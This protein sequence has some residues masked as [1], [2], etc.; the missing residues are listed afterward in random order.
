MRD[1]P[2]PT[3]NRLRPATLAL[4]AGLLAAA[5]G[6]TLKTNVAATGGSAGNVSH[7]WLTVNEVWLA[8]D[9][10]TPP[11]ATSGWNK[12][13]LASPV[14]FDLAT[15]SNSTLEQLASEVTTASGTYRQ[16]HLVLADSGDALTASAQ[17]VGIAS[18]AQITITNASGTLATAPLEAAVPGF[19]LTIAC[20]L[21]LTGSFALG[22]SSSTTTSTTTTGTSTGATDTGGTSGAT[23]G[24]STPSTATLALT[25]D[26]ARDVLPYTYGTSTG[27][28]LSPITAVADESRAGG[29]SGT[30]DPSALA[31]GSG[32][33]SVS[34]EIPD[35]TSTHHVIVQRRVVGSDG[36][37]TLYPLPT[38][39]SGTANYDLVI[40]GAGA[41]TIIVK[42]IP[43]GTGT[44]LAPVVVQSTPFV[45]AAAP[46]VYADVALN[47]TALPGGARVS[48]YQTVPASGEIPYAIDGSAVDLISR[49]LPNDAFAL[50]AGP[51]MVGSYASGSTVSLATLAPVEGNGGFVI[52]ADGQYRADTLLARPTLISGTSTAPTPIVPPYPAIAAGGSAGTMRVTVQA[53][54]GLYDS[55]FVVIAAGNRVVDAANV[56]SLLAA[57]GGTVTI[58]NVPGGSGLAASS[59]VPYQVAL[60][61]WNSSSGAASLIRVA[62]T[63]STVFGN[64]TAGSVTLQAQ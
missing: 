12:N 64:G 25:I 10:D 32:P 40:A 42:S 49:R 14:T 59:G 24:S 44:A 63:T 5:A 19:G 8:T 15:L 31:S 11:E 62:T 34:A 50:G 2:R 30:V 39:S 48:F 51:L 1:S 4:V 26:G 20:D 28:I 36:S 35:P 57:G 29:I 3:Q 6:C 46:L 37:F 56:G 55:G 23:L 13:V 41:Q 16:V 22:G 45:L 53:T 18:N 61:A 54:P 58:P 21:T 27:Y 17:A 47:T 9:A 60:R 52:G 33:I 43:V 38:P 7:L